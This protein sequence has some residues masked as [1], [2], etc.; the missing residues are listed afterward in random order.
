LCFVFSDPAPDAQDFVCTELKPDITMTF[1]HRPRRSGSLRAILGLALTGLLVADAAVGQTKLMSPHP[2]SVQRIDYQG[3]PNSLLLSNGLVE[4]VVVPAIGRVMQLRFAGERDGPFWE[5]PMLATQNTAPDANGWANFGGDK[6]WPS[7]QT[8]WN[9]IAGRGWPPPA[10]FDGQPMEAAI[11]G[12]TVV[13]L[14]SSIDTGFGIRIRRRIELLPDRPVMTVTTAYEKIAGP[15][16]EVG[17]WVITQLK[18]PMLVCVPLAGSSATDTGYVP[19]LGGPPHDLRVADGLLSL[20][21]DPRLHRKIG[22]RAATLVWV[23][24]TELLRIDS[25]LMAGGKYPDNGSSAEV[26]TNADPLTY[27]ELELLGPLA[28]LAAGEKLER[29]SSYTLVR[30]A[31]SNPELDVSRLLA[32][33][34][35]PP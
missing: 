31:G 32:G 16:L 19:L 11:E 2:R 23:G 22:M 24:A 12:S 5:N 7:P 21:R 1:L 35:G 20:T 26:Y 30:R 3:W 17:V 4:A 9:R 27:V 33:E 8:D 10:A 29:V 28:R 25:A 13:T 18:D 6:A 14:V 15:P 34:S